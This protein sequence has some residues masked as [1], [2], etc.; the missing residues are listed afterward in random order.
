MT[1]LHLRHP[2]L[3][4]ADAY[5]EM[6]D[7]F[8]R[9]GQEDWPYGASSRDDLA[10]RDFAAFIQ[11]SE[12]YRLGRN[13]PEGIVPA[14]LLLLCE[15]DRLIGVCSLRHRLNEYLLEIGG[16]IGYCIRPA[17]RRRGYMKRFLP[18]VLAEAARLGIDRALIS[19]EKSNLASEKVIR[20]AGGELEDQRSDPSDGK[21]VKRFW[22]ETPLASDR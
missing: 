3:A 22:V 20:S 9:L 6:A 21:T 13:L 7:E 11:R 18:L 14:S 5:L 19:C 4:D 17:M 16:H 10:R 12:A 1:R 2:R 15:D 8:H